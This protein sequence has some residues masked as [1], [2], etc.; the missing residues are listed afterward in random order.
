MIMTFDEFMNLALSIDDG[1]YVSEDADGMLV[2]NTNYF[3]VGDDE[4]PLA[5]HYRIGLT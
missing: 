3:I 5:Y 4:A 1:A 2:I